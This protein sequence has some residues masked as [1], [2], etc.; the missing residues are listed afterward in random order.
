MKHG[1]VSITVLLLVMPILSGCDLA[2]NVQQKIRI[3]NN[4]EVQALNLSRENRKLRTQV[5]QLQFQLQAL[6]AR[7]N[8]LQIKLDKTV[9]SKKIKRELASVAP[10]EIELK[11][12]QVRFDIYKWTSDQ[13]VSIGETEMENKN[14]EKASQ[15]FYVFVK[16][17]GADAQ[18]SDPKYDSILFQAGVSAY[19]SGDHYDWAIE[20]LTELTKKFPSSDYFRGA[21]LWL[22]MAQLRKG[23][24]EAFYKVVEE[25]RIKYR[26]TSEWKILSAYYED[27][28]QKFKK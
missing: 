27:F 19:E 25:F 8:F 5:D 9:D 1:L 17:F 23:D 16:K 3:V 12:D 15:F 10:A 4:F 24:K 20:H 22:G 11:N 14:Y 2:R 21:K 13:L 26:N 7:N 6:E 28:V 18:R